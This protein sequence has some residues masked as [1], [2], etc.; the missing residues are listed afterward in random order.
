VAELVEELR[1]LGYRE[2]EIRGD[3]RPV[4][5]INDL[6]HIERLLLRPA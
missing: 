1:A 6:I 5:A 4:E 2:A 3:V